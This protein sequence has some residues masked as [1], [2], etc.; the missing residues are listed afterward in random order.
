M[1]QVPHHPSPILFTEKDAEGISYPHDNALV[2]MLKV[3]TSKV[4][5]TL[6][7]IGSSVN[8]IFK[9]VLDQLLIESPKIT[10]YATPYCH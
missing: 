7:D 5:K 1:P 2:I 8:I 6:V 9:S 3:A 10:L 4:T